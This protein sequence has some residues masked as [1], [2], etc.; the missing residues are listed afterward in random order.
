MRKRWVH[1]A[2]DG[3]VYEGPCLVHSLTLW[4]EA[5]HDY[6]NVYD[7]RDV[8][9]GKL[10]VKMRSAPLITLHLDFGDGVPFDQGIYIDGIDVGV[11]TTVVFTP[12]EC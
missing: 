1:I 6:A 11:E 10:F 3:L 9:S 8:V 12:I 4:P 5:I 7:G 2:N